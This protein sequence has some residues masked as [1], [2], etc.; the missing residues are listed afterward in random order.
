MLLL[1]ALVA[2]CQLGQESAAVRAAER[3]QQTQLAAQN[4]ADEYL[5]RVQQ[6]AD[7]L[8]PKLETARQRAVLS[9]RVLGLATAAAT[10]P[11]GANPGLNVIDMIVVATLHY[12]IGQRTIPRDFG[13]DGAELLAAYRWA[14]DEA[15]SRVSQRLSEQHAADLRLL[16]D[17]WKSRNPDVE[18]VSLV[19]FED[20]VGY[21]LTGSRTTEAASNIFGLLMLDPFA[22]LSPT[23]REI[24]ESR[25]FAERSLFYAQRAPTLLSLHVR[26]K[27]DSFLATTAGETVFDAIERNTD[28]AAR[29]AAAVEALPANIEVERAAALEQATAL[30]AEERAAALEQAASLVAAERN[31]A[32]EQLGSEFETR[33]Q[34]LLESMA[35]GNAATEATLIELQAT[36]E[37]ATVLS[38]S[39]QITLEAVE[40][41]G[42]TM[43]GGESEPLN[44]AEIQATLE[45]ADGAV[46]RLDQLVASIGEILATDDWQQRQDDYRAVLMSTE[47]SGRRVIDHAFWRLLIVVGVALAGTLLIVVVRLWLMRRTAGPASRDLPP[48]AS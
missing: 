11:T 29:L 20:F 23:N 5:M 42:T 26:A 16:I 45:A 19:R 21:Q 17:E 38:E 35:D 40:G 32:I 27:I 37:S 36:I 41:L 2:G 46:E 33:S 25:L 6:A 1:L 8:Y 34:R 14:F 13:D 47:A 18:Y 9:R 10:V 12:E 3:A 31:D 48:G 30:L 15:W 24:R 44:L 4:F 22:G 7:R 43:S 28:S 39:L